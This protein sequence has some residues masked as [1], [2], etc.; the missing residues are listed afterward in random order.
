MNEMPD[1]Q[2]NPVRDQPY[3]VQLDHF[4]VNAHKRTLQ[5]ALTARKP[6]AGRYKK[7]GI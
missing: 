6:R 1:P 2:A 7:A 5:R 4:H 3:T